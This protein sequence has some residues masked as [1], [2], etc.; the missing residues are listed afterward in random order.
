MNSLSGSIL[1]SYGGSA[2]IAQAAADG[3]RTMDVKVLFGGIVI[4][5]GVGII[6]FN[7]LEKS[8]RTPNL[9]DKGK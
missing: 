7:K 6:L 9:N 1:R 5:F 4:L 2:G 3:G 8:A